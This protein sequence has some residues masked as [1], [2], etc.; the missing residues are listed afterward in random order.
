MAIMFLFAVG[1]TAFAV[2]EGPPVAM[3]SIEMVAMNP[4]VQTGAAEQA[5]A[6][7]ASEAIIVSDYMMD[8]FSEFASINYTYNVA[9]PGHPLRL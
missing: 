7:L 3:Q 2:A 5:T 1:M 8:T 4:M 6:V 9:A